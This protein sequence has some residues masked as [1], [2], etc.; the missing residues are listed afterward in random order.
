VIDG[1]SCKVIR[2]VMCW[3]MGSVFYYYLSGGEGY[4]REEIHDGRMLET[5]SL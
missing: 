1:D 5:Q 3:N 4:P 2:H